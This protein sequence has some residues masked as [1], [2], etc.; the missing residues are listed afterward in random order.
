MMQLASK[1]LQMA[2]SMR[3]SKNRN[4][5]KL[6]NLKT[7][8]WQQSTLLGSLGL[9]VCDGVD[10]K[11]NAALGDNVR[12]AVASLNSHNCMGT[13][14]ANHWEDVHD[15]VSQPAHDCPVLDSRELV[16]LPSRVRL[17]N[18]WLQRFPCSCGGSDWLLRLRHHLQVRRWPCDLHRHRC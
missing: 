8:S 3:G 6:S 2:S 10:D 4:G 15:W 5:Y 18:D 16:D 17:P 11:A 9:S 13:A 1:N 14:E 7:H 12:D